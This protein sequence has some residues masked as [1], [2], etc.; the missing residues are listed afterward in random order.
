MIDRRTAPSDKRSVQAEV[1]TTHD[2]AIAPRPLREGSVY[3]GNIAAITPDP[4]PRVDADYFSVRAT[5]ERALRVEVTAPPGSDLL[6]ALEAYEPVFMG[7]GG[8]HVSARPE[9]GTA[10]LEI[11]AGVEGWLVRVDDV[12]NLPDEAHP[13]GPLAPL[14][15]PTLRYR[16]EA[17]QA[18]P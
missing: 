4:D 11:P 2:D 14:G 13:E 12:R 18:G 7:G 8:P 16:L 9:G 17:T 5:G 10:A 6:P 1:T 15:G 3:W